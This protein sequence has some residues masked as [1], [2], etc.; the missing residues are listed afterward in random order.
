MKITAEFFWTRDESK[1]WAENRHSVARSCTWRI[2]FALPFRVKWRKLDRVPRSCSF[3]KRNITA[4][5]SPGWITDWIDWFDQGWKTTKQKQSTEETRRIGI[6]W[7]AE[8]FQPRR[9]LIGDGYGRFLVDDLSFKCESDG[10]RAKFLE[11]S[12]ANGLYLLDR[13]N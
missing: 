7:I 9:W 13:K 3:T 1:T 2:G 10:S 6:Q 5:S 8:S 4:E 11:D 12:Y